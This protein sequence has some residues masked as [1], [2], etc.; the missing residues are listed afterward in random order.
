MGSQVDVG[1]EQ[2]S[3][4]FDDLLRCEDTKDVVLDDVTTVS[5]SS[6]H[7]QDPSPLAAFLKVA[8][9][10][11]RRASR[12]SFRLFLLS[13]FFLFCERCVPLLPF[14]ALFSAIF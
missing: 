9:N 12:S 10:R 2:C 6:N 1:T 8:K 7:S 13:L 14:F 11:A 3:W 5:E 4:L